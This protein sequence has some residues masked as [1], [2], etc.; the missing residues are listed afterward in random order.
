MDLVAGNLQ[1]LQIN[2]VEQKG[3]ILTVA[4]GTFGLPPWLANLV[5]THYGITKSLAH[6]NWP[7]PPGL[8]NIP[9]LSI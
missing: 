9:F 1:K 5:D 4:Y 7:P 2:A 8:I 6:P 3:P